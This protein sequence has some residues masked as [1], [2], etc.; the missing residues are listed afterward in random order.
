MK[1]GVKGGKVGMLGKKGEADPRKHSGTG[2]LV[3]NA[4][5]HLHH[6]ITRRD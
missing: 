4:E 3:F 1:G 2:V 5:K 6:S